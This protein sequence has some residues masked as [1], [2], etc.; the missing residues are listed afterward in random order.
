MKKNQQNQRMRLKGTGRD[1]AIIVIFSLINFSCS[2]KYSTIFA[3]SYGNKV[4]LSL[5]L[6]KSKFVII[7]RH[8]MSLSYYSGKLKPVG[9]VFLLIDT[10][11]I[12]SLEYPVEF[13]IEPSQKVAFQI[14]FSLNIHTLNLLINDSI[15]ISEETIYRNQIIDDGY[16]IINLE[17]KPDKIQLFSSEYLDPIFGKQ[18]IVEKSIVYSI[19]Y[20]NNRMIFNLVES[21]SSISSL[22]NLRFDRKNKYLETD[23]NFLPMQIGLKGIPKHHRKMARVIFRKMK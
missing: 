10:I 9:S 12:D 14:K 23:S 21:Y 2:R 22:K 11:P 18:K 1:L 16:R 20:L 15:K 17:F 19:P 8:G 13:S 6:K 3:G 7:K 4:S 5:Y